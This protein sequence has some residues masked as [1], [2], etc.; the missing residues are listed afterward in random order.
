MR[1]RLG[2][3]VVG[4]GRISEFHIAAINKIEDVV[5]VAVADIDEKRAKETTKNM[6]P[7]NAI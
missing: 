7:K 5:L 6:L 3:G 2:I 1:K 4:C